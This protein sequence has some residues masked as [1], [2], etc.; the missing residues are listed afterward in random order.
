MGSPP[1]NIELYEEEDGE[2]PVERWLTEELTPVEAAA[3][4]L[5]MNHILQ[6]HGAAVV[7]TRYGRALGGGLYEFRLDDSVDELLRKLELER[8]RKLAKA[9]PGRMLF[10]VFFHVHRQKLILLLGGYNKGKRDSKH[11]QQE[12]IQLARERLKAW[13]LR[14]RRAL[15]P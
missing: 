15:E 10:R 8:G 5:A 6:R 14:Q 11:H 7:E 4:G 9:P 3:L 12:Q 2:S 13:K 1:Y